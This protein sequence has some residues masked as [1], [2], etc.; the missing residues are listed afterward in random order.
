M[1]VLA[2]VL[3]VPANSY[4]QDT[5]T[6]SSLTQRIERYLQPYLDI[7]HLSGTVLVAH[8]E[9]VIYERSFGLAHREQRTVN[10]PTTRFGVGS[11]NKPM[12]VV[13]LARL[14]ELEKVTLADPLSKYLPEFPRASEITVGNLLNHSA[15]IPHRVTEPL[16]ETRPQ[17]ATTMV[18]LAAKKPLAFEPG[19]DSVYS[20]AGFSVLARVLELAAG[21]PYAELLEEHVLRPAG[22]RN[23]SDAGSR[24]I[25]EQRAAA[26]YFGSEGFVNAPPADISYLV[27]AGSVFSTPRDLLAMQQTLLDGG[28]GSTAQSMLVRE[29]GNLAWNGSAH[30]Y[31]AFAD[32]H[33][34]NKVAVIVASNLTSGALDRIRDALPKMVA[35]EEV[36]MPAP[37]RARAIAVDRKTLKSYQGTYELR[38]GS[39]L[40]LRV[41]EEGVMMDEWLLIPTAERTLFS[42]Q[43]YAEIEVVVDDQEQPIRLDWRIGDQTYPLPR[44]AAPASALHV[45]RSIAS[46]DPESPELDSLRRGIEVMRSRATTDPTSWCYQANMHGYSTSSLTKL[47]P[48]ADTSQAPA[49]VTCADGTEIDTQA[50][51]MP[52]W[53]QCQHGSYFFVSWHRMYVYYFERILRAAAD[54]P[55]LTVPYWPWN[56]DDHRK[57]PLPL[58]EPAN[59]AENSLFVAER[60]APAND[61]FRLPESAVSTDAAFA[62]ATFASNQDADESFGG[63]IGLHEQ[64]EAKGSSKGLLAV[65]HANI[66]ALT[67]GPDGWMADNNKTAQDPLFW[68][69]H[70]NVDRLWSQWV[71]EHQGE[72]E[73]NPIHDPN[74]MSHQFL[75]FDE[76]GEPV[77]MS[78]KDI[79]DT[80]AQLGYV[81]DEGE[82][83]AALTS[84]S[85]TAPRYEPVPRADLVAASETT[86]VELGAGAISVDLPL[87]IEGQE[88]LGQAA[89]AGRNV[90][91][92]IQGLQF[93]DNP[94]VLYEIYADPASLEG[95]DTADDS[96][97]GTLDFFVARGQNDPHDLPVPPFDRSLTIAGSVAESLGSQAKVV[98]VMRSWENPEGTDEGAD[99]DLGVLAWFERV[100]VSVH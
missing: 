79:V 74:W 95:L 48:E 76:S 31:R 60:S 34:T 72:I 52:G 49:S 94:G 26:Y 55:N 93:Q 22:M 29:S 33:A 5:A 23:T 37:I 98:L 56:E 3:V 87:G 80:A 88:R 2:L 58:R 12:T 67:G 40:Q 66:H 45:R 90:V 86:R 91:I 17:T 70:S 73:G 57:V 38:P 77:C 8:G 68:L 16:D 11:V 53:N 81:Y 6:P 99:E 35:G 18:E 63:H 59:M 69:H 19:S 20:S 9:E 84:D 14:I 71:A 42:P 96:F 100:T 32:Y 61:G 15:G 54:D 47:C 24:S 82:I 4:A 25:L 97:V 43:D 7:E 21:K 78:G 39:N 75:F 83:D 89:E 44:V 65:P 30:G 85:G 13:A 36:P 10:T 50:G 51:M 41:T 27:G 62:V 92:S 64:H 28:F 46:Y 1:A